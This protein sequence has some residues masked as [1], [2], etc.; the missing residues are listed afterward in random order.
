[1]LKQ[2][3]DEHYLIST[4]ERRKKS[5]LCHVNFLKPYYSRV[6]EPR[7]VNVSSC[8]HVQS[9]AFANTMVYSLLRPWQG[10][11]W[12]SF[13]QGLL[14]G[15]LRNTDTLNNLDNLLGHLHESKCVELAELIG[16]FP[17]LFGDTPSQTHL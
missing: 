7:V 1:M 14:C 8:E 13:G 5:Q 3:S 9:A 2:I 6:I 17:S 12:K 11:R 15:R 16:R 10:Q 4:P